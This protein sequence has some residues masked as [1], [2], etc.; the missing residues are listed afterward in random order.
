[1]TTCRRIDSD[2]RGAL[3]SFCRKEGLQWEVARQGSKHL[4]IRISNKYV[5]IVTPVAGTGGDWRGNKNFIS[6]LRKKIKEATDQLVARLV[7]TEEG[8]R[9]TGG[10]PCR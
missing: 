7:A 2:I 8:R 10:R 9:I 3:E 5:S 1:M 6:G 4:M